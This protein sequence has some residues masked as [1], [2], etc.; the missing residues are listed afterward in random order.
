MDAWETLN[1]IY[2]PMWRRTAA[3]D[4]KLKEAGIPHGWD[5]C[6]FHSSL[7]E[8]EYRMEYFPIPVITV[9][10]VCDIGIELDSLLNDP[11]LSRAQALAFDGGAVPWTFE[12]YG[13]ENFLED[14]CRP[15]MS[16]AELR[17]VIGQSGEEEI[18]IAFSLPGDCRDEEI[19]GIAAACKK[20]NTHVT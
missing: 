3:L 9:E 15:D 10:G 4:R 12:V 7:R 16:S 19:L 18:G 20:W 2:E 11:H 13:T 1:S 6:A 5:Y 14:L 8:G 17:A